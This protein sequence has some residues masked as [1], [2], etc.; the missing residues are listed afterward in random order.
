MI[1]YIM[2][3]TISYP[4]VDESAQY[5]ITRGG[6][7]RIASVSVKETVSPDDKSFENILTP[8]ARYRMSQVNVMSPS[9]SGFA[10]EI[11]TAD[12]NL[13]S[14]RSELQA[15]SPTR[16][17]LRQLERAEYNANHRLRRFGSR[18]LDIARK[19]FAK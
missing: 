1:S 7:F 10:G 9:T 17:E 5:A 6:E 8:G 4:T 13:D 16:R 14:N 11:Q 3:E 15:T 19:P 18:I 12:N 2:H